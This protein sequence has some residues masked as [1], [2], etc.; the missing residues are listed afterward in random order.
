MPP[1]Y[2]TP[3]FAFRQG[4]DRQFEGPLGGIEQVLSGLAHL[5]HGM[6]HRRIATP[7]VK[8]AA[9]I[10]ADDITGL[11]H[12]IAGNAMHHLVVDRNTSH[13]G[14]RGRA[15]VP[16]EKWL[17][18]PLGKQAFHE[19]IQCSSRDP[20]SHLF[21][22]PLMGFPDQLPGGSHCQHFAR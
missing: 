11:Q 19:L 13:A 1:R 12:P 18:T 10:N 17:G 5:T 8:S 14:K 4:A 16:L 15:R 21:A 20:G 3:T 2:L 9:G 22:D 6:G 7:A